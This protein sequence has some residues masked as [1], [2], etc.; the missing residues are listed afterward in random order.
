LCDE[1]E[2]DARDIDVLPS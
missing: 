2:T 1:K